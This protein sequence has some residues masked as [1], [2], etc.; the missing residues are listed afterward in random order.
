[1]KRL[2]TT[3]EP[4]FEI[5]YFLRWVFVSTFF[6]SFV[7]GISCIVTSYEVKNIILSLVIFT[8]VFI[9]LEFKS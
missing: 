2:I 7:G 4:L 3:A 6:L 9:I 1:M 5:C 8:L